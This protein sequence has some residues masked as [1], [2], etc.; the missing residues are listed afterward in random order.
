MP[1]CKALTKVGKPC[2]SFARVGATCCYAHRDLEAQLAQEPLPKKAKS[3]KPVEKKDKK[4]AKEK[5][6]TKKKAAKPEPVVEPAKPF[7]V[8]PTKPKNLNIELTS[9][10]L[11]N[12]KGVAESFAEYLQDEKGQIREWRR[13]GRAFDS[14]EHFFFGE[15]MDEYENFGYYDKNERAAI[16]VILSTLR[17]YLFTEQGKPGTSKKTTPEIANA[18]SLDDILDKLKDYAC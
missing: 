13:D 11:R 12:V 15:F 3:K 17:H 5:N 18:N 4:L 7:V 9:I 14:L 6:A 10:G 8:V 2:K 1:Q 16:K